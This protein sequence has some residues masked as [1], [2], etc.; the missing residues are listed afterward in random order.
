MRASEEVRCCS[1]RLGDDEKVI[2]AA[3]AESPEPSGFDGL[4]YS[5]LQNPRGFWGPY[6]RNGKNKRYWTLLGES[7]ILDKL[8]HRMLE[9]LNKEVRDDVLC[10]PSVGF[11][12]AVFSDDT[13]L[14]EIIKT[15]SKALPIFLGMG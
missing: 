7:L 8:L 10:I 5:I 11:I 3:M 2:N 15:G 1:L 9:D 14:D 12:L 13:H 4:L 6:H